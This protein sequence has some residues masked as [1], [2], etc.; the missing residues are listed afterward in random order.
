MPPVTSDS[1]K[2]SNSITVPITMVRIDITIFGYA[3]SNPLQNFG[4]GSRVV[5]SKHVTL[6]IQ[7]D[8]V[9]AAPLIPKFFGTLFAIYSNDADQF[10]N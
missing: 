1:V 5:V 9:T 7:L 6:T 8:D 4:Y 2:K 10:Y 3:H